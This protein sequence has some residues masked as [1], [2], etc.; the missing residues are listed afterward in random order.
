LAEHRAATLAARREK[1]EGR[2]A[3]DSKIDRGL[4]AGE[5]GRAPRALA[6]APRAE[7]VH[8][9]SNGYCCPTCG[10][11]LPAVTAQLVAELTK[12]GFA[13]SQAFEAIRIARRVFGHSAAA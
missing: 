3:E 10:G 9:P 4:M 6:A 8:G 7:L 5:E 13:E 11:Q 1:F 2:R 12:A